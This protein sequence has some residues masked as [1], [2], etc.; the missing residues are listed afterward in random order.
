MKNKKFKFALAILFILTSTSCGED[1]LGNT[2]L[3]HLDGTSFQKIA[4][5]THLEKQYSLAITNQDE[6]YY[7]Y[8]ESN[9]FT[10]CNID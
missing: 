8:K 7:L 6:T 4:T 1:P 10:N 2:D 9:Y 5:F 3:P